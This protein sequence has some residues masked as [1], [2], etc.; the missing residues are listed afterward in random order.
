MTRRAIASGVGSLL[1]R[2]APPSLLRPF[3]RVWALGIA[4]RRPPADALRDL[5]RLHDDLYAR[6][7]HLSISY[8]DGVH[9]KH[10]LMAYHDFFVDRLGPG[11]RVLDIG[12]GKGELAHDIAER[13]GSTVVG[14][15]SNPVYLEFARR[16]FAHPRL[17]FVEADALEFLPAERFDAV[18][19][20]N[21]LEHIEDRPQLLRR[22]LDQIRPGRFLLRVPAE[23]RDWLVPLRRELGLGHFSDPTHYIEYDEE[24]FRRELAE[25]G[26]RVDELL[27][28]WGELWVSASPAG[29]LR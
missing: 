24:T 3:L 2:L 20:S 19:L 7:D 16:R 15:D 22:V 10:R 26:L 23:T 27:S 29:D 28:V 4:R 21:V 25:A 11:D 8:D 18:V 14:I 17:D 5:I 6:I 1:T 12:C 13:A 9:V